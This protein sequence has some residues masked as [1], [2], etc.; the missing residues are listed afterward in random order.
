MNAVQIMQN[1]AIICQNVNFSND[2]K[3]SLKS[4]RNLAN[5]GKIWQ[6]KVRKNYDK[7]TIHLP[8]H[9]MIPQAETQWYQGFERFHQ[10][11]TLQFYTK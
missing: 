7:S 8:R 6:R 11:K 3:N 4:R 5:P 9:K 2:T 10:E 1:Y